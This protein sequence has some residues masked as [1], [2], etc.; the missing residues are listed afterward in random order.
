VRRIFVPQRDEV[1]G[2]WKKLHDDELNNLHSSPN[3][4]RMIQSR[5]IWCAGRAANMGERKGVHRVLLRKTE[6]K[7]P[8]RRPRRRWD[9]KSKMELQEVG[10]GT[11]TGLIWLK[12]GTGCGLL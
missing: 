12:T 8:L 6:G 5:R 7:S 2:E 1:R 3:I 9:C 4:I 11:W 10:W